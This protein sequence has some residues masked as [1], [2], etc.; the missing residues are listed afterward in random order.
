MRDAL[1]IARDLDGLGETG[2]RHQPFE[3]AARPP[4][5]DE[6]G[7][8]RE[9]GRAGE[10]LLPGWHRGRSLSSP[11][12]GP[13]RPRTGVAYRL[14]SR[15]ASTSAGT[16]PFPMPLPVCYTTK[17]LCIRTLV[18][19]TRIPQRERRIEEFPTWRTS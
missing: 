9:A 11:T 6:R 8:R 13:N 18:H 10:Q 5:L 12:G 17:G 19:A 2:E 1:A 14:A 4:Q 15:R 7:A 3:I 16:D